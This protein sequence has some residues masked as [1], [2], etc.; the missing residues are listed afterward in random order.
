MFSLQ[1]AQLRLQT[2][3]LLRMFS[4]QPAPLLL[5]TEADPRIELDLVLVLQVLDLLLV[6]IAQFRAVTTSI[7]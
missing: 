3:P 4:L 2:F 1:P 5:Q 6:L 7:C